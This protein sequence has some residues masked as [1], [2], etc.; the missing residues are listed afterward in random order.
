MQRVG[1]QD[2]LFMNQSLQILR[3]LLEKV[4][5]VRFEGRAGDP[6]GGGDLL[7]AESAKTQGNDP[8]FAG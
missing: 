3:D 1:Y 8:L 2:S 4:V 7:V 6:Q 5:E